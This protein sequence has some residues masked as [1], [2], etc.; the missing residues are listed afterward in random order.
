[1]VTSL[2]V[3]SINKFVASMP[4]L[5]HCVAAIAGSIGEK[6]KMGITRPSP[7]NGYLSEICFCAQE[8]MS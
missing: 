1:M 5:M 8:N 4:S 6:T 3:R 7:H 2:T